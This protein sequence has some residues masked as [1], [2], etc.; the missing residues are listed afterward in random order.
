MNQNAHIVSTCFEEELTIVLNFSITEM[1]L[2]GSV[3]TASLKMVVC[4]VELSMD[5]DDFMAVFH[6]FT[7]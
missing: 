3:G 2:N 6:F 1:W 7:V 5:D 4:G